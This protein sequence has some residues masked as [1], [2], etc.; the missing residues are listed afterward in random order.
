MACKS[1]IYAHWYCFSKKRNQML[2]KN[3]QK[4][5]PIS[6]LFGA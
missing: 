1:M 4:K 3:G 2:H 6:A 5:A